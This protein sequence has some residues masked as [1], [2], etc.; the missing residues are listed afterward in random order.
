MSI[1]SLAEMKT[2][3]KRR[4]GHPITVVTISD[5]QLEDIINDSGDIFSRYHYGS[6]A[7]YLDFLSINLLS[8]VSEYNLSGNDIQEVFD[9]DYSLGTTEGGLSDLFSPMNTLF[10]DEWVTMGNHPGSSGPG[11]LSLVHYQIS[12]DYVEQIQRYFSRL[13]HAYWHGPTQTIR[14]V[15]TPNDDMTVL[16]SVYKKTTTSQLYNNILF[17]D[18]CVAKAMIQWS[19]TVGKY[20]ATAPGGGRINYD[21][22]YEMG[23]KLEEDTMAKITGES[24]P[25]DFYVA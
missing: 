23:S 21:R 24:E 15:P 3:I 18:L 22:F 19:I 11:G 7:T 12:M 14:V 17:K 25:P 4:L 5:E 16:L 8:G 20:D 9:L 6:D 13:Y 1:S 2:Y 10:Y